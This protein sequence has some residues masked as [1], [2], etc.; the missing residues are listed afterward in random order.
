[1]GQAGTCVGGA[2]AREEQ[3]EATVTEAE[4]AMAV[5]GG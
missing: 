4:A 2:G 3:E 1:M 5:L